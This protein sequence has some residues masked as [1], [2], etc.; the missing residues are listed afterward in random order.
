M[1]HNKQLE[2]LRQINMSTYNVDTEFLK[3]SASDMNT[4]INDINTIINKTI[5]R[6]ENMPTETKE[7]QGNA[8]D[9]FSRIAMEQNVKE[10]APF[11]MKLQEFSKE[12]TKIAED[13]ESTE[14]NTRL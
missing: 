9:E 1:Q 14:R 5:K 7:W 4:Y 12:L 6:I 13:F 8:A 11:I 10:F 3:Q 2:Q